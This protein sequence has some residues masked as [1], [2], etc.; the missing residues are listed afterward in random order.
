M[1][2][3]SQDS[4]VQDIIQYAKET[5]SLPNIESIF[6]AYKGKIET[7]DKKDQSGTV[8]ALTAVTELAK[9]KIPA[10]QPYLLSVLPPI[11][12]ACGDKKS[13]AETRKASEEAVLAISNQISPNAL[14]EILPMLY[15][16]LDSSCK[17]QTRVAAL[18]AIASFG[19]HAPEQLSHAMPDVMP[20]VSKCVVELKQEVCDAAEKA[21]VAVCEVVGNR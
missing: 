2:K 18:N 3:I 19:D 4:P 11:L 16:A 6:N 10:V 12:Q 8:G 9:A 5:P 15:A 21:L 13:T 17:W 14:R 1:T 7:I 20:E